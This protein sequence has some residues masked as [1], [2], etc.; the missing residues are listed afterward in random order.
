MHAGKRKNKLDPALIRVFVDQGLSD[1]E[2]ASRMGWTLG[3]LRVRCS[4]L[5]ISLR[6]STRMNIRRSLTAKIVLPRDIV[7]QLRQRAASMGVLAAELASDLLRTI[8]QD[9][10]YDAVLDKND[11]AEH[12]KVVRTALAHS[13]KGLVS[14]R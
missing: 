12:D 8:V 6:R 1:P 14:A 9:D 7:D 13:R 2:I 10:L 5:K 4:Q 11:F 3:T